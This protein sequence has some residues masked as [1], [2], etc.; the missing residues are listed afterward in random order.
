MLHNQIELRVHQVLADKA[1]HSR[2]P[3][4]TFCDLIRI[5]L[6]CKARNCS[7]VAYTATDVHC[8]TSLTCFAGHLLSLL[9]FGLH[10]QAARERNTRPCWTPGRGTWDPEEHVAELE[11]S[12]LAL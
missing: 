4:C 6:L 10:K 5:R 1:L 12:V 8:K 9:L 2:G 11:K 7:V 3:A